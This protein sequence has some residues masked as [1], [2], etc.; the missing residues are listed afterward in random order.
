[1]RY[2]M[3]LQPGTSPSR[4]YVGSVKIPETK[5]KIWMKVCGD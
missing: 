2:D 4:L 5:L 1:M 3:Q